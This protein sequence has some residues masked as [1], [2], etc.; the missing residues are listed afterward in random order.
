MALI[1][2]LALM[3]GVQGELRDRI[4]GS[5]AHVYVYKPAA[6]GLSRGGSEAPRCRA[7]S[8]R[9]R[10]STRQGDDHRPAR[11][12][13]ITLK[14]ID[15]AIERAVTDSA[16]VMTERIV[17]RSRLDDCD[18]LPA[19]RHRRRPGDEAIGALVGDTVTMLTPKGSLT[20]MGLIAASAAVQR[21]RHVSPR[22]LRVRFV[23]RLR[24]A[25]SR[26]HMLTGSA[27][28]RSSNCACR[29]STTRRR[30]ADEITSAARRQLHG[31][32]LDRHQ[33]VALFRPLL[34]KIAMGARHRLDRRRGGAEH[35]CVADPAGDG[36][37]AATSPS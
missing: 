1:I 3:T 24:V 6:S 35:R 33:P 16:G 11:R 13:F 32:G 34:E 25:R 7:S 14:G 30:V 20:P 28:G 17:R 23:V 19:D 10:R 9:R 22:I 31:A 12:Q 15:P 21:R 4:L 36:K 5:T 27:T 29:T 26:R 8:A 37:D 2:A 18:G